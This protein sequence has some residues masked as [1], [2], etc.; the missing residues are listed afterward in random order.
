MIYSVKPLT[1]VNIVCGTTACKVAPG[2]IVAMPGCRVRFEN[3]SSG[4][5][6]VQGSTPELF[7]EVSS[8]KRKLKPFGFSIDPGRHKTLKIG[9]LKRGAYPYAVFCEAHSRYCVGSSMPII[10]VP[11]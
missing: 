9:T 1:T 6:H 4:A 10:I 7:V 2:V 8:L 3:S 11:K 5:I